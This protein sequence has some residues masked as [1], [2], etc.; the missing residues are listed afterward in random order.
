M[1]KFEVTVLRPDFYDNFHCKGPDCRYTCCQGWRVDID[2][3]T[4]KTYH[5]LRQ[6]KE[7]ANKLKKYVVKNKENSTENRYGRMEMTADS[8]KCPFHN[9]KR[10]C[11]IQLALGENALSLTC[12]DYP[13]IKNMFAGKEGPELQYSFSFSCEKVLEL[14]LAEKEGIGFIKEKAVVEKRFWN[15]RID[16]R[17][18]E[19]E[20]LLAHWEE[21]QYL[22]IDLLQDRNYPLEQRLLFLGLFCRRLAKASADEAIEVIREFRKG[23][24]GSGTVSPVDQLPK[25]D[26]AAQLAF[27]IDLL[28]HTDASRRFLRNGVILKIIANLHLPTEG[29]K[30]EDDFLLNY[31]QAYKN[32]QRYMADKEH[33]LE[34]ILVMEIISKIFPFWGGTENI[35]ENYLWLCCL[36]MIL[37]FVIVGMIGEKETL[38]Q[39][40]LIDTL[41]VAGRILTHNQNMQKSA[42]AYMQEHDLTSL[43]KLYTLLAPPKL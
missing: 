13:R 42:L 9:E 15:G 38:A 5:N 27:C 23:Y 32:Y 18:I 31:H 28:N 17:Q 41:T 14:L 35:W 16:R 24:F 29:A 21:I 43:A 33:I 10:L 6:P 25:A 39:E 40:E 30:T 4:F 12:R 1:E 20:P 34:N 8:V 26:G 2:K 19:E 37:R 3:K 36:F 7:L 22:T 11:D